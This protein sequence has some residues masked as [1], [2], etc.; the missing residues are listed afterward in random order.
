[1]NQVHLYYENCHLG[2]LTYQD[3]VFVYNS[4][5]QGEKEYEK[6]CP[7]RYEYKLKNSVNYQS[8]VGFRI[9]QE[10][11]KAADREDFMK[12]YDIK[13]TDDDFTKLYKV[14]AAETDGHGYYI[15]QK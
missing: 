13:A 5:I 8:P 4:D 3:N 7:L 11:L 15:K 1:M 9:F 14:A 2:V 12:N 10:F 6:V